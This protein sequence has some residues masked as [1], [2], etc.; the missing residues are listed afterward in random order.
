M[1]RIPNKILVYKSIESNE[2]IELQIKKSNNTVKKV[3]LLDI[4]QSTMKIREL[5][6][7]IQR[8]LTNSNFEEQTKKIYGTEQNQSS[9][10]NLKTS[11]MSDVN[12]EVPATSS[13]LVVESYLLLKR[14]KRNK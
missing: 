4:F 3:S 14:R 8:N 5:I 6:L 11:S 1:S 10:T 13:K 9:N 2:P 7:N 12:I